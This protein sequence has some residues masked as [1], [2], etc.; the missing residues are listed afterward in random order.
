MYNEYVATVYTQCYCIELLTVTNYLLRHNIFAIIQSI[1]SL[2]LS[3][4]LFY[5][6][7]LSMFAN[8]CIF[9]YCLVVTVVIAFTRHRNNKSLCVAQNS[10]TGNIQTGAKLEFMMYQFNI[11]FQRLVRQNLQVKQFITMASWVSG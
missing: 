1:D 2:G 10:D 6:M 5:K 11:P 8:V 3:S 4:F 9:F 7:L